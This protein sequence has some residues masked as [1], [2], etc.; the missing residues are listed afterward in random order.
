M[1]ACDLVDCPSDELDKVDQ[2]GDEE[3]NG[4]NCVVVVHGDVCVRWD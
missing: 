2:A 4:V 3:F 1:E